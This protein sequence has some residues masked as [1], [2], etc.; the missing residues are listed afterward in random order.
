MVGVAP[1]TNAAE[2]LYFG[3]EERVSLEQ[4]DERRLQAGGVVRGEEWEHEI[5]PSQFF[6]KLYGFYKYTGNSSHRG[7]VSV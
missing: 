7:W 4:F 6:S 5:L 1:I 2:N 3:G